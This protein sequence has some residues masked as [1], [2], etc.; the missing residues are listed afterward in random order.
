MKHNPIGRFAVVLAVAASFAACSKSSPLMPTPI[1]LPAPSGDF[2][3]RGSVRDGSGALDSV[4]VN[5]SNGA[6]EVNILTNGDGE[7]TADNLSAGEWTVTLRKTGYGVG[8]MRVMLAGDTS[9]D[10]SL[11]PMESLPARTAVVR[12]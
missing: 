1:T 10:C 11:Q 5:V 12:K 7:F 6:Y 9:I 3:L 4:Q 8:T 2:E